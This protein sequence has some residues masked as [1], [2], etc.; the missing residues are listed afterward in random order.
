MFE[1]C[2]LEQILSKLVH[3]FRISVNKVGED[4]GV[5]YPS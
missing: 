3:N 5:N 2:C 1:K 4:L